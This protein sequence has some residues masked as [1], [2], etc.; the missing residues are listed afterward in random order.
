MRVSV[1]SI[2]EFIICLEAEKTVHNNT[3]RW[4][5]FENPVNGTKLTAVKFEV[6]VHASAVIVQADGSEYILEAN[7]FCGIDYKDASNQKAGTE[8]E[9]VLYNGLAGYSKSRGWRI[10]P[11]VIYE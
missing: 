5:K 1:N 2:D 4:A 10:L 7:E 11:G 3:L 6:S 8:V 9:Q